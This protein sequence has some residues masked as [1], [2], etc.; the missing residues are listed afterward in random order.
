M[1][2]TFL[3]FLFTEKYYLTFLISWF[4]VIV[5]AQREAIETL[6]WLIEVNKTRRSSEIVFLEFILL[7]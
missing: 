5:F 2:I 7:D 6:I 3:R 4:V 1:P